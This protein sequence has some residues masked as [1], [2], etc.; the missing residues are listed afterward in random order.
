MNGYFRWL[1]PALLTA[2]GFIAI[3]VAVPALTPWFGLAPVL[4]LIAYHILYL[5][6][7]RKPLRSDEVDSV[8]YFGF[9]I[10]VAALAAT[11]IEIAIAP[12]GQLQPVLLKFGAGL[13]ATGYA[14]IA[15]LHLQSATGLGAPEN[16]EQA[17]DSYVGR[18]ALLLDNLEMAVGQVSGLA[19][20]AMVA[21]QCVAEKSRLVLEEATL[22][23]TR[24][25]EV[26][27]RATLDPLKESVLGLR[28]LLTDSSF[29]TEREAFSRTLRAG[30]LVSEELHA[31]LGKLNDNVTSSAVAM[32]RAHG[33]VDT[34]GSSVASLNG[35][36]AELAREGGGLK[37][38]ASDM[39]AASESSQ[40]AAMSARTAADGILDLS[41]N[42][43]ASGT[44]FANLERAAN[45]AA[46]GLNHVASA[47][48]QLEAAVIHLD[49]ARKAS[50]RFA[51]TLQAMGEDLPALSPKIQLLGRECDSLQAALG[52]AA[53][54]LESD[55]ERSSRAV[56][57]LAENLSDV[58]QAII[59]RT[60]ERH[61][62]V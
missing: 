46:S 50:E 28:N 61:A 30:I 62:R 9:L 14:V 38:V 51:A 26:E 33:A 1:L 27:L 6:T 35:G 58:A 8:Y 45:S 41:Q 7:R 31:A 48:S 43:G 57:L 53:T 4:P 23:A 40:R 36:L 24:T 15:R 25:F 18:S 2:L 11:A 22:G 55:V 39:H 60:R 32:D 13:F 16:A 49:Q 34:L 29:V 3:D 42:I 5:S 59:D 56:G 37:R 54:S 19:E 52:A 10:T 17:L 12:A 20:K 44:S 21:T 47:S